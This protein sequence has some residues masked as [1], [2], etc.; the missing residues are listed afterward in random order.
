M[1]IIMYSRQNLGLFAIIHNKINNPCYVPSYVDSSQTAYITF[2]PRFHFYE[3]FPVQKAPTSG[4]FLSNLK[5]LSPFSFFLLLHSRSTITKTR[6]THYIISTHQLPLHIMTTIPFNRAIACFNG[7]NI[8]AD[9]HSQVVS[10]KPVVI[11]LSFKLVLNAHLLHHPRMQTV[12]HIITAVENKGIVQFNSRSTAHVRQWKDFTDELYERSRGLLKS[13]RLVTQRPHAKLKDELKKMLLHLH[14]RAVL[15]MAQG[16]QPS[17][18]EIRGS[19][20]HNQWLLALA[21]VAQSAREKEEMT[22]S[23][24]NLENGRGLVPPPLRLST[25]IRENARP[26]TVHPITATPADRAATSIQNATGAPTAAAGAAITFPTLPREDVHVRLRP[27]NQPGLRAINEQPNASIGTRNFISGAN[28]RP[29]QRRRTSVA[30]RTNGI[31]SNIM[32]SVGATA[33]AVPT[34][35]AVN[36]ANGAVARNPTIRAPHRDAPNRRHLDSIDRIDNGNLTAERNMGRLSSI[37]NSSGRAGVQTS[38]TL[39]N[40]GGFMSNLTNNHQMNDVHGAQLNGIIGDLLVQLRGE[41]AP[42]GNRNGNGN[43]ENGNGN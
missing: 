1:L 35:N 31:D 14:E 5:H 27:G 40:L 15:K 24:E 25:P 42:N 11:E 29:S 37:L 18:I 6:T 28:P 22:T 7:R 19:A 30:P 20:V 32:F 26:S 41:I 38:Q 43:D 23:M 8:A 13:F 21:A 16:E 4:A 17:I 33:P 10:F 9:I 39:A 2:Q 3:R 36:A 34:A 12:D